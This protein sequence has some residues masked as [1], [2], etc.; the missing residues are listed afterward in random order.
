LRKPIAVND[1]Q[2]FEIISEDKAVFTFKTRDAHG[3]R[4]LAASV[5]C[6]NL[7]HS[8]PKPILVF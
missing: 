8:S 4:I 1:L 6:G 5:D 3:L 7:A 2:T